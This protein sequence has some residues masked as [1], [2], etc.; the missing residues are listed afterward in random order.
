MS[1]E[2]NVKNICVLIKVVF[3]GV[4]VTYLVQITQ[5]VCQCTGNIFSADNTAGMSVYTD[6]P[7]VLSALNMLP[8]H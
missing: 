3:G 4:Q 5:Q 8:V 6:I 7:A 1:L 2:L